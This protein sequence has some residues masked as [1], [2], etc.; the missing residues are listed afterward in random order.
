M[1]V[2]NLLGMVMLAVAASLWGFVGV[3]IRP[4][5]EAGLDS[6]QINAIRSLMCMV[7]FGALILLIDRR[8]FRISRKDLLLFVMA[9]IGKTSMD[10]F[11]VQAQVMIDLSLAALLLATDCYFVILA[12]MIFNRKDVAPIKIVSATMGFIGC[13]FVMGVFSGDLDGINTLGILMGLCA[14]LSGAV[15]AMTMKATMDRGYK[16]TTVLFYMF[17]FGSIALI[18]FMDLP[19]VASAIASDSMYIWDLLILCIVFTLIA[20]E[21]YTN[22]LKRLGP[23]TASI[24]L[25]LETVM[26][27][28]AGWIFFD[29]SLGL[30]SIFGM[31][32]VLLSIVI[33]NVGFTIR[34]VESKNNG[35]SF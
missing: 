15:Y 24:I 23:M 35:D 14:G 9:S 21:L 33:M 17:L 29:E 34:H 4:L 25:F 28:V 32:L 31:G 11:Y 1:R 16:P 26:A 12:S 30:L 10:I 27:A 8:L 20:Y 18:P 7:L 19:H 22:G 3:C 5:D 13:M 2:N 6:I